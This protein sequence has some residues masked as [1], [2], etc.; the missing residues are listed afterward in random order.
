[1]L[2]TLLQSTVPDLWKQLADNG[3]SFL[4]LGVAVYVLWK[5]DTA[6]NA[7]MDTYLAEDRAKMMDVINNNTKAF[8]MLKDTLEEL[9]DRK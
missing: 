9:K 1:M 3:L 4:F 2:I 7:K 5:R 8:G 6:T